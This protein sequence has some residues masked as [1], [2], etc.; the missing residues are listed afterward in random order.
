M[1]WDYLEC[2][3][4]ASFDF[5]FFNQTLNTVKSLLSLILVP[6]LFLDI[7]MVFEQYLLTYWKISNSEK[8]IYHME[9]ILLT[10]LVIL[11][12]LLC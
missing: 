4:S 9:G 11:T 2:I 12:I 7:S 3:V 8:Y 1:V 10:L 6:Y 5:I